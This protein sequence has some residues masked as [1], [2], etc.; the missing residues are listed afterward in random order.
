MPFFLG[1]AYRRLGKRY[2]LVYVSFDFVSAYVVCFAKLG[3]FALYK[4]P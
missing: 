2:F 1:R 3:L 4:D